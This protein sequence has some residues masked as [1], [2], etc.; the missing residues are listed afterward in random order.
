[1]NTKWTKRF[2]GINL[3]SRFFVLFCI[4]F[5]YFTSRKGIKLLSLIMAK[6]YE[7][8]KTKNRKTLLGERERK[9]KKEQE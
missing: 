5:K 4:A 6:E 3:R 1:M 2:H 8:N 7:E 9:Q